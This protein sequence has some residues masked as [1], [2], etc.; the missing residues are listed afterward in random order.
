MKQNKNHPFEKT[1]SVNAENISIG[2]DFSE[3]ISWAEFLLNPRRLR[4]SDFLMRW[5]QGVWSEH[6]LMY[7]INEQTN[8]YAVPYG[9]SSAAPHDN[10]REFELHFE[11][12]DAAGL[13]KVKKPDLLIFKNSEK[14]NVDEIIRK[15]GGV[16]ELPFLKEETMKELISKALVGIECENS[17][18]VAQKM[19]DF[20]SKFTSQKRLDGKLGL[21]NLPYYQPSLLKKKTDSR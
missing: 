7:S 1:L 15:S 20:Q 9:P 2:L 14:D 12:L 6:R 4:G 13:G 21:K 16:E 19:P 3:Y 8:F 10:V 5:S 18:W 11:R 17:L